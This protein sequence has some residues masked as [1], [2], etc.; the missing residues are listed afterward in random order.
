MSLSIFQ[1]TAA[2]LLGS[3]MLVPTTA[4]AAI[5]TASQTID[6]TAISNL[7]SFS[8]PL[9][10]FAFLPAASIGSLANSFELI[11]DFKD[12]Q[13]LRITNG[14]LFSGLDTSSNKNGSIT[15]V[16][17]SFAD[18]STNGTLAGPTLNVGQKTIPSTTS[19]GPTFNVNELGLGSV[20]SFIE[21]GGF[22]L[23]YDIFF[24]P[25]GVFGFDA[26]LVT[27]GTAELT[28]TGSVPSV[29]PLPAALPL[30][31]SGLALMGFAGW[32]RKRKAPT[33]T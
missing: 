1:K 30:F 8:A 29:V 22:T 32:Y 24:L 25:V 26:R 13:A 19:F 11:V 10:S 16:T 33:T 9:D 18:F 21:F 28:T 20:L 27:T 7:N 14:S 5:I 15:N 12:N 23:T 2:L 3:A 6:L 17:I 31:G 4:S